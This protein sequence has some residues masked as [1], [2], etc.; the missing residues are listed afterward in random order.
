MSFWDSRPHPEQIE[1]LWGGSLR[2]KHGQHILL[3]VSSSQ[4]STPNSNCRPRDLN[5]QTLAFM[6]A[7]PTP[8]PAPLILKRK[9][10]II[11]FPVSLYILLLV[12]STFR[13]GEFSRMPFLILTCYA[14]LFKHMI[15]RLLPPTFSSS[16]SPPL[17]YTLFTV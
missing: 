14:F 8:V 3:P 12:Y 1:W 6:R 10:R 11:A 16:P 13:F 9:M 15:K 7:P 4:L 5:I 17:P 2:T